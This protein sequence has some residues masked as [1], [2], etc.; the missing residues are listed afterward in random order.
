M[1]SKKAKS[2]LQSLTYPRASQSVIYEATNDN[3]SVG[4]ARPSFCL[5][6]RLSVL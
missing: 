6:F 4:H 5:Y 1:Q 3:Y 2:E